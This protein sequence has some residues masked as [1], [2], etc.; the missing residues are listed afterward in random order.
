M[1]VPMM[2]FSATC[3]AA[4]VDGAQIAEATNAAARKTNLCLIW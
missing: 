4:W 1:D 3:D 2:R